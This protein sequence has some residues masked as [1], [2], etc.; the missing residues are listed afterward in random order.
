MTARLITIY[1]CLIFVCTDAYKILKP[2]V[3]MPKVGADNVNTCTMFA[4]EIS[5]IGKEIKD[6]NQYYLILLNMIG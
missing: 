6:T 3:S 2:G 5:F 1:Y 4:N